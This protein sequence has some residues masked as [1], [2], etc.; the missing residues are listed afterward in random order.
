[1]SHTYALL[2]ISS[3]AYTEIRAA[4]VDANYV[5]ALRKSNTPDEVIDM[6]GIGLMC[7]TDEEEGPHR[8]MR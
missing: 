4:L 3:A 8:D 7:V 2:L 5:H 1:M 6:H